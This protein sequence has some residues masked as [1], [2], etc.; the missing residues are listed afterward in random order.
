[1]GSYFAGRFDLLI[2]RDYAP[3][4]GAL[5]VPA[6]EI[7]DAAEQAAELAFLPS[8]FQLLSDELWHATGG[9]LSLRY[10]FLLPEGWSSPQLDLTIDLQPGA[11]ATSSGLW[12]LH[13]PFRL[14]RDRLTSVGD[15]LHEFAHYVFDVG[16]EYETPG[17]LPCKCVADQAQRSATGACFMDNSNR[18][19]FSGW[20]KRTD[21][22][23]KPVIYSTLRELLDA[24]A[25]TPGTLDAKFRLGELRQFC[26]TAAPGA[27]LVHDPA[28]GS[29]HHTEHPD[30]SGGGLSC[31]QVMQGTLPDGSSYPPLSAVTPPTAPTGAAPSALLVELLPVQRFVLALDCSGSM[32]GDKLV[33][34]REGALWS[35][36]SILAGEDLALIS[37]NGTPT[38]ELGLTN[39][40]ADAAGSAA[41]RA[42]ASAAVDALL[43]NGSTYI[44]AALQMAVGELDGLPDAASESILL[45][46]DGRQTTGT[47]Q[48]ADV[49]PE[50]VAHRIRVF[51]IAL[52]DDADA[53][54]LMTLAEETSGLYRAVDVGLPAAVLSE[55]L[56]DAFQDFSVLARSQADVLS[57]RYIEVSTA[58]ST[59]TGP[60]P[61]PYPP[62][63]FDELWPFPTLLG[64]LP[65]P[66]VPGPR[67]VCRVHVS[68]GST[69]LDLGVHATLDPFQFGLQILRPDGSVLTAGPGVRFAGDGG[70]TLAVHVE[71][72]AEGVWIVLAPTAAAVA[73]RMR[74]FASEHNQHIEFLVRGPVGPVE[75]DADVRLEIELRCGRPVRLDRLDVVA[76]SPAGWRT[77]K[78]EL[79]GGAPRLGL[80]GDLAARYEVV[81]RAEGQKSGSREVHLLAAR[82]AGEVFYPA[83]PRCGRELPRLTAENTLARHVGRIVRRR[84][85]TLTY[86][87]PNPRAAEVRASKYSLAPVVHSDVVRPPQR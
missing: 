39:M 19:E 51:V 45:F 1:M 13:A 67:S 8:F 87:A 16:D 32:Y 59:W 63:A 64:P 86:A 30:G 77:Y 15:V 38:L 79:I 78:A 48:P 85:L 60:T 82:D 75:P 36:E 5:G 9:A 49:L 23:G 26:W 2:V 28:A 17:D 58:T 84:R 14:H 7:P 43:A 71:D 42:T 35:V 31:W 27:T 74:L 25:A 80:Y 40:P 62:P 4:S 66:P 70:R 21:A 37:F 57:T 20:S 50:L 12:L 46:S 10:V 6:A 52:G 18:H 65:P 56:H 68:A 29:R 24:E 34:L 44:G 69:R 61:S 54:L 22:Y 3:A 72:P 55:K 11:S 81:I 33:A 83:E 53:D 76:S 41:L 73:T 47:V